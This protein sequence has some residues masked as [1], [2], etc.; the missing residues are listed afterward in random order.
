MPLGRDTAPMSF[1]DL[2]A[3]GLRM[4]RVTA[5]LLSGREDIA[6]LR[7]RIAAVAERTATRQAAA[8][9]VAAARQRVAGLADRVKKARQQLADSQVTLNRRRQHLRLTHNSLTEAQHT[10]EAQRERCAE[11]AAAVEGRIATVLPEVSRC[12]E[13][14]RRHLLYGVSRI[15]PIE[16]DRKGRHPERH[17]ISRMHLSSSE[18]GTDE[19]AATALGYV[20]HVVQLLGKV[21]GIQ[22]RYKLYPICSRSYVQED[23][24]D[25]PSLIHPL[26]YQRGSDRNKYFKSIILLNRD[27][28][29]LLCVRGH[30]HRRPSPSML[31]N[32]KYLMAEGPDSEPSPPSSPIGF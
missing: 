12:I 9:A 15:Y 14:R 32:L 25:M 10:L 17:T 19:E 18:M 13:S 28:L 11:V 5:A 26:F 16:T 8:A 3:A 22:L 24:I 20:A 2:R 1:L 6:A 7:E 27:I 30:T 23:F 31:L 29:Q 4:G 21:W